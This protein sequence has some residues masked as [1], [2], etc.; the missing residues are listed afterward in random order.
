[1]KKLT[2]DEIDRFIQMRNVSQSMKDNYTLSYTGMD[3]I[4]KSITIVDLK[5][6]EQKYLELIQTFYLVK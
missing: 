5:I 1:M 3:R 6:I 4:S 2:C